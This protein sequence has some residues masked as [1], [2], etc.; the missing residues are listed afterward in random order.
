[1]A[2]RI[3]ESLVAP[4]EIDGS[5]VYVGASVG[6]SLVHPELDPQLTLKCAESALYRAKEL[7]PSRALS[8]TE[9]DSYEAV[10]KTAVA[11]V[12]VGEATIVLNQKAVAQAEANHA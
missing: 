2:E 6:I 11:T 10:Y 4:F 3:L 12:A 1:M 9:Y 7:G 8:A 5:E